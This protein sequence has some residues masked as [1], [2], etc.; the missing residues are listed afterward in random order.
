MEKKAQI[1]GWIRAIADSTHPL[2]TRLSL[3]LTDFAPNKNNQGIPESEQDNIIRTAI[4]TPLKINFDGEEYYSHA[5]AIP[6]GPITHAYPGIYQDRHVIFAEAIIW[7]DIYPEISSFL[8]KVFDEGIHT[9]WEIYY[10]DSTVIEGVQ[11]LKNTVFA[12][13]CVVERPAYADRTPILAIAQEITKLQSRLSQMSVNTVTLSATTESSDNVQILEKATVTDEINAL[14][15]D[16]SSVMDVLSTIYS[17]LY[18]MLDETR[19]I[20]EQLVS[21]DLPAI[22]EQFTQLLQS[23]TER[24]TNLQNQATQNAQTATEAQAQVQTVTTE[25]ETL[26]ALQ[27]TAYRKQELASI[28]I[29]WKEDRASFYESMHDDLFGEYITDLRAVRNAKASDT[30]RIGASIPEPIEKQNFSVADLAAQIRANK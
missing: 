10:T 20:E 29:E 15:T 4:N 30:T 27:R 11:W 22:S 1:H 26:K 24:F 14:R 6:I 7:N 8:K 21:T 16:I 9:S 19:D 5:S 23:I 25:L 18:D 12:G 17:G 3:I 2:Q 13:T 28:G